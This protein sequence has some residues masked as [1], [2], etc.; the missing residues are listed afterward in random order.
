MIIPAGP[1]C[2]VKFGRCGMAMTPWK[3]ERDPFELSTTGEP[4]PGNGAAI[5]Q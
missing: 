2:V 5:N 3:A 4:G 1:A